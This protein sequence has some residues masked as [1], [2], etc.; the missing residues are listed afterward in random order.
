VSPGAGRWKHA[1]PPDHPRLFVAVPLGDEALAAVTDVVGAVRAQPLPAGMRDVRWVRLEGLHLTLTFIGPVEPAR[2]ATVDGAVRE[3]VAEAR[4]G[5]GALAGTGTFP[6]HGRPRTIWI[7]VPEGTDVLAGL[8]ARLG[9]VLHAAGKPPDDRAFQAHLT[10]ARCDGLPAGP[11]VAGRLA[12]AMG[13][14]RIPFAIDRVVLFESV[15]GGGPAR[16]RP[17]AEVPLEL[18][19]ETV[20]VYHP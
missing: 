20:P 5:T 7:G 3:A 15:T 19:P 4:G 11:L 17:L 14:R 2:V 18:P 1:G 12:E 8:A 10:I 13:D 16:Y 9:P 6:L